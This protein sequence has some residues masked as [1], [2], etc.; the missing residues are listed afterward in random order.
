MKVIMEKHTV[1]SAFV[2]GVTLLSVVGASSANAQMSGQQ[3]T[4]RVLRQYGSEVAQGA[5]QTWDRN[6]QR[7]IDFAVNQGIQRT[8]QAIAGRA[9]GIAGQLLTPRRACAPSDPRQ[10]R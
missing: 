8:G 1:L 2:A 3:L 9:G 10:C 4:E 6:R 7:V 5:R